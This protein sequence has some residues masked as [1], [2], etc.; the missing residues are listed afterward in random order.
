M[1]AGRF[2]ALILGCLPLLAA[3]QVIAPDKPPPA[4]SPAAALRARPDFNAFR[5]IAD[6][7]R[8]V[9]DDYVDP[10]DEAAFVQRCRGGMEKHLA[11][12]G[13]R[14]QS[15]PPAAGLPVH[16]IGQFFERLQEQHA[17]GVDYEALGNACLKPA[18][19]A[20]DRHTAY[21]SRDEF[22]EMQ[23]GPRGD[24]A[25]VGLELE[26][27]G[28]YTG[29]VTAFDGTP[30]GRADFRYGDLVL[31]VDGQSTRGLELAAVAKLLRGKPGSTAVVMVQREGQP[32]PLRFELQREI[33]RVQTVR[34][35][36]LAGGALYL[37]LSQFQ[38]R[39]LEDVARALREAKAKGS[40]TGLVLDLRH[41]PGGLLNSC[42]GMAALFL[43][44]DALVVEL[45]GRTEQNNR[46]MLARP[47]DY[48]R[49]WGSSEVQPGVYLDVPLMV[50][51]NGQSA[52][53]S[54][55]LAAALQDHGRAKVLGEKSFGIGTVQ[56]ILPLGNSTALKLTTARYYRPNGGA[57]ESSPVIPDHA[58]D[59]AKRPLI[60]G[61]PDDPAVEAARRL[62][63][64]K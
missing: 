43:P 33:I 63:P 12:A 53:C 5:Q 56:T 11:G 26:R 29:V 47:D 50:M 2:V 25:A 54:E 44:K 34:S 15:G 8:A 49:G 13:I 51:V 28:E 31:G 37:R 41:N 64:V 35:A 59:V 6:V 24:V 48:R 60:F 42:V 36:P 62:L 18:L 57:M 38:D 30:A 14:L 10:I 39:S 16:Q 55:I 58:Y 40:L 21:L 61:A 22:R 1:V 3:G 32:A 27:R 7:L 23:A 4:Q 52:A 20:L 19:E 17:E 45:R 9:K 46:R